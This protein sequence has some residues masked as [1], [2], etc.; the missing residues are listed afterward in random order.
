MPFCNVVVEGI[1]TMKTNFKIPS[2]RVKEMEKAIR[3]LNKHAQKMG[4][5]EA[6]VVS[7]GEPKETLKKHIIVDQDGEVALDKD[8]VVLV[9]DVEVEI[10]EQFLNAADAEWKV[11]GQVVR[12]EGN[13]EA[14]GE[15]SRLP[16]INKFAEGYN[17]KCQTCQ[18]AL[19]RG[20][21]VEHKDGRKL[22]VG[23][24]CLKQYTGADGQAII[25]AIEFVALLIEG[26]CD[27]HDQSEGGYGRRA[28]HAIELDEYLAV[29]LAV[30]R[31]D[32]GYLK[33][34]VE[35][36]HAFDKMENVDCTRNCALAHFVGG[37]TTVKIEVTDADKV[38]AEALIEA[39]LAAEVPVKED[40]KKDE[41][42][43]QC[44]FLA[45]RGW[46]SEK[47]AGIAASM[48]NG[49]RV[50]KPNVSQYVGEVGKRQDFLDLT[51]VAAI[52]QETQY[53]FSTIL[54]FEDAAG[55]VLTWF[56]SGNPGFENGKKVSVKA[57]VK[58]QEEYRGV[59]QTVITRAKLIQ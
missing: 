45:E 21:V 23:V 56:A 48:V 18:H 53:G 38:A 36:R 10:P 51:V 47:S 33:R 35:D 8:Y 24:E 15:T 17:W 40:G 30:V 50:Q 31:R 22:I 41:Y 2:S 6:K 46:I 16:E 28:Y 55:N 13:A 37:R 12:V 34:W 29:C 42:A 19:G 54:K 20:F 49:P 26:E 1:E 27:E 11:I 14:V 59:K 3:R 58:A 9:R 32:K 44:K 57:T 7:I 4:Y 5:G 25:K 43:E 39:W 52:P